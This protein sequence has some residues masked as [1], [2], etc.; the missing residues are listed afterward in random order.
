MLLGSV[1]GYAEKFLGG[2][3]TLL[4]LPLEPREEVLGSPRSR[5]YCAPLLSSLAAPAGSRALPS[6]LHPMNSGRTHPLGPSARELAAVSW[7][8]R[9]LTAIAPSSWGS[10]SLVA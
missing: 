3:L 6:R 5:A 2:R 7:A 9:A 1:L 8:A 10:L 4:D